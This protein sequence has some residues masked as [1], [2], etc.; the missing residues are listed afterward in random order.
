MCLDKYK[1]NFIVMLFKS[2]FEKFQ[3]AP[4]PKNNWLMPFR[5]SGVKVNMKS[6]KFDRF[7]GVSSA[8][9][10]IQTENRRPT[11]L[12]N[13]QKIDSFV[14]DQVVDSSQKQQNQDK[15]NGEA[16]F[17]K[18]HNT[19]K[20]PINFGLVSLAV[21]IL[22][23]SSVGIYLYS[24]NKA[25][26]KKR[27]VEECNKYVLEKKSKGFIPDK[28]CDIKLSWYENLT[29]DSK[30]N[31]QF[32]S[33]KKNL[34]KQ[35]S[36]QLSQIA[37]L[38]KDIRS[39]RQN[40]AG[41]DPNFEKDLQGVS[42][43][44]PI[45]ILDKQL[46]LAS[47][48]ALLIQKD[49]L[50]ASTVS[51]FSSIVK[52]STDTDSQKEQLQ[53]KNYDNLA[54]TEKYAQYPSLVESYNKFK[55]VLVENNSDDWYKK[56]LESPDL[57]K[58]KV[59]AGD[60]FKSLIDNSKFENTTPPNNDLI[61]IL[62]DDAADKHIIQVAE[63]R[64]YKKRPIALEAN[65]VGSNGFR[66]QTAAKNAFES[67]IAAAQGDG[68]SIGLVSGYRSINDQKSLF[69]TRFR[70]ESL[71]INK[72]KVYSDAEVVSGKA[73][74]AINKVLSASSIPGY[75]RHH[76]GYTVD[77]TDLN[78]KNDFTLFAETQGY[79][80]MSSNNY[81]NAKKFGFAPSY[82]PGASN[83]GPE[84]ESWEYVYIGVEGLK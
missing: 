30:A 54:K 29:S 23:I 72:G 37:Q 38:D 70:N 55:Q 42:N 4:K 36:D 60:E 59:L 83:Q 58:F 16:L 82:P 14:A 41:L 34:D 8:T 7:G 24:T 27:I 15:L 40:L 32:E 56:S 84:P 17:S 46:L 20:N 10:G 61:S 57:Y 50:I 2:F 81:F 52:I 26:E 25:N 5:K 63:S 33:I 73:D 45:N 12:P 11:M 35:E 80:W 13:L 62:G 47:L 19:R 69:Q 21:A 6:I 44:T 49:K 76:L 75:S 66:L 28:S 43:L 18:I 48:K 1:F 68:V 22:A 9:T 65:L 71:N 67:M 78:A 51:Q 79:K 31:T 77:I 53:L 74:E 3:P 39:A 64:G